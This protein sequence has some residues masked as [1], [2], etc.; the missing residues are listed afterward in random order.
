[1]ATTGKKGQ[2]KGDT[3]PSAE[4]LENPSSSDLGG[5]NNLGDEDGGWE[6]QGARDRVEGGVGDTSFSGASYESTSGGASTFSGSDAMSTVSGAGSTGT[7]SGTTNLSSIPG[8]RSRTVGEGVEEGWSG[9]REGASHAV[10]RAQEVVTVLAHRGK[11]KATELAGSA[12]ELATT[13][14]D[15]LSTVV[16]RYPVQS[17]L[18]GFGFGCLLGLLIPRR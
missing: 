4:F 3:N 6:R 8:G 9:L 5:A 17:L 11:E 10:E 14:G 15:N 13:T 7:Q 12:R 16:R 1:M 18:A 2:G